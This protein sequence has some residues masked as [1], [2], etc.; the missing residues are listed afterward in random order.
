[1]NFSLLIPTRNRPTYLANA[2]ESIIQTT[3]D[4]TNTEIIITFDEDDNSTRQVQPNLIERFGKLIRIDW[5]CRPR[6]YNTS[7]DYFNFMALQRSTGKYL[8]AL[9]D[10]ILFMKTA[11][12]TE[13]LHVLEEYLKNFPDGVVYGVTADMEIEKKRNEHHWF[14]CFPLISRK[15][16]EA[17]GFFF[18][19]MIYRDG[20][21]WD[22]FAIYKEVGRII[23]LRQFFVIQHLS[24]RSGRRGNDILDSES[25][26]I[27]AV[28]PH[29]DAGTNFGVHTH[30]LREYIRQNSQIPE[31]K[32]E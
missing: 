2:I 1:M 8:V 22:I 18:D 9:N 20:A 12:D 14:S 28:I 5:N 7:Q 29:I 19:P 11:W 16:V 31:E 13:T 32:K 10:D 15:A 27:Q 25:P 3:S 6:S 30:I 17:L 24:T 21:D 4:L 23:D 26:Q